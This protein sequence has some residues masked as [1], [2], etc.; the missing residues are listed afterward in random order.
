MATFSYKGPGPLQSI[1]LLQAH[2]QSNEKRPFEAMMHI[3]VV[4]VT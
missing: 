3:L 4:A 1:L 2:A